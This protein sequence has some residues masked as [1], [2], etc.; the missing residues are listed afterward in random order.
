MPSKSIDH[1]FTARALTGA[2]TDP[3]HAGALS[4]MR[5][6]YTKTLK[7]ADAVVWGIPFDAAVSNRPGA[8]FGPQAIRRASAIMDNDPQYPFARD[9][10]RKPRGDRLRRLPAR[11][12][13]PPEDAGDDRARSDEDPQIRRVPGDARRRPL[14]HMAAPEGACGAARQAGADTVRRAPGHLVRRWQAHRPR[15]LRRPRRA[16]RRHRPRPF[17]PDR[18]PDACAGGLR[19]RDDLRRN[20]R[21]NADRRDRRRDQETRRRHA[22]LTSPSISTASIRPMRRAPARR[23]RAA[24]PRP[25]CCRS[26]GSSAISTSEAPIS[27]RWRRPTTMPTSRRLPARRSRSIISACSPNGAP[28]ES[29][30]PPCPVYRPST[31]R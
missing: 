5:R 1:A 17:D 13:Q 4:F 8:R 27:S 20:G 15:L 26:C 23:S 12:R 21:G 18:H 29:D 22:L 2:A 28:G 10:F 25:R 30:E 24:R 9:L 6:K 14:R 11:L 31:D 3:T 7:G 19:H 16:R